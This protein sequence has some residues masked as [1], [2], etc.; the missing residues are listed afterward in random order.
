MN[1]CP[2]SYHGRALEGIKDKLQSVLEKIGVVGY[3]ES[4]ADVQVVDGLVEDARDAVI[5]YQVS[6]NL[7]STVRVPR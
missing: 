4:G 5:E 3:E 7:L 6:S 2:S 1:R